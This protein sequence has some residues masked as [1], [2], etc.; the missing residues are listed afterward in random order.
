MPVPRDFDIF[1]P[2]AVRESLDEHVVRHLVGSAGEVQHRRPEQGVEIDDVLADEMVLVDIRALQELREID[3]LQREMRL[4]AREVA[5]RRVEPDVEVLAGASGIGMPRYGASREMSQSASALPP[6]P[7]SPS[8]SSALFATSG[9]GVRASASTPAGSAR[10]RDPRAEEEVL[11]RLA[12]RRGADSVEYG[13][14]RSV[15]GLNVPQD[16]QASPY[17]SFAPHFGHSP[18][19]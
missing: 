6:S 3:P 12:H 9:G 14:R 16:S 15:G 11:R 13:F 19:M 7:A 4:E 10:M 5:D 18:L 1:S 17:W 2:S 8:H